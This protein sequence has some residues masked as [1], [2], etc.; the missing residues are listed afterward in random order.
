MKLIETYSNLALPE[1]TCREWFR[2]FKNNDF[3]VEDEEC[4]ECTE[5]FE[6]EK[7]HKLNL[8]NH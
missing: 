4:S 7:W 6:D 8:K 3:D 1:T 2:S 5:N